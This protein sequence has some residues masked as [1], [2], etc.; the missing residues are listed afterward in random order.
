ML[1]NTYKVATHA[2]ELNIH[3]TDMKTSFEALNTFKQKKNYVITFVEIY[4]EI[5]SL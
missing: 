2:A 5:L 3:S 4:V 1:V